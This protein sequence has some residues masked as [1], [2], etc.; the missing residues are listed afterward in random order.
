MEIK[1]KLLPYGSVA[2]SEVITDLHFYLES[3]SIQTNSISK[4]KKQ[5]VPTGGLLPPIF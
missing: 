2:A 4:F 5:A 3:Y 1:V